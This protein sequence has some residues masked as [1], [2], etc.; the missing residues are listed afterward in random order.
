MHGDEEDAARIHLWNRVCY[1]LD[2]AL[3]VIFNVINVVIFV[4]YIQ[5]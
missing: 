1:R 2:V 4:S 3:L 5:S